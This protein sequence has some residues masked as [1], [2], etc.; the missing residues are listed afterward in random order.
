MDIREI[1][2][3]LKKPFPA[4][5][6]KER[7]LPGGDRWFYIPWQLIR[8]RLDEVYPEWEVFYSDP[9]YLGDVTNEKTHLCSVR[10][11]IKLGDFTRWGIGNAPLVLLSR[12]GN[13]MT[14]GTPIE[15]ATAD[16]FKN[17][18]ETWGIAAY[19]DDQIEVSRILQR[20]GD[21]RAALYTQK[22]VNQFNKKSGEISREQWLAKQGEKK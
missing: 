18:A 17:A 14:R 8:E 12:D 21:G 20:S 11:G 1:I 19:I 6:H 2:A 10:C 16:A 5:A 13:D 9:V 7:K 4:S 15:R 3:E 22:N